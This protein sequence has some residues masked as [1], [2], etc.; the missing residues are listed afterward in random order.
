MHYHWD[1][2]A[3]RACPLIALLYMHD[4]Y[5]WRH[6]LHSSYRIMCI[7]GNDAIKVLFYQYVTKIIRRIILCI[8]IEIGTSNDEQFIHV[9]IYCMVRAAWSKDYSL[10]FC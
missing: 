9:Y 1:S 8:T 7:H 3:R 5:S 6:K 2:H 4:V 10:N